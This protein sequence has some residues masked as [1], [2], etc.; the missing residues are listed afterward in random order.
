MCRWNK[1][2]QVEANLAL[3]TLRLKA[4]H[5]EVICCHFILNFAHENIQIVCVQN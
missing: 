4:V 2:T 3:H 1:L 5:F